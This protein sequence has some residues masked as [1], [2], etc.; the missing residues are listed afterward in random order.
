MR[1]ARPIGHEVYSGTTTDPRG[2]DVETWADPVEVLVFGW[3]TGNP[4]E[5]GVAGHERTDVDAVV[6]A[7]T[8]FRPGPNDRVVLP[9]FGAFDVTGPVEDFAHGPFDYE[10]GV[11]VNLRRTTG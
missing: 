1:A 10:P 7:P 9:G 8:T 5:P 4:S 11:Q 2:N 6:L 3:Y